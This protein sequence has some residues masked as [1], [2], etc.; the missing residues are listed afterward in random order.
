[1]I[2]PEIP[3]YVFL[4]WLCEIVSI[5]LL[6]KLVPLLHKLATFS[7]WFLFP[8]LIYNSDHIYYVLLF[9][10]LYISIIFTSCEE[11]FKELAQVAHLLSRKKK[12]LW[13]PPK[14]PTFLFY[15]S[16]NAIANLCLIFPFKFT[17]FSTDNRV[18]KWYFATWESWVWFEKKY[19]FSGRPRSILIEYILPTTRF[20]KK[21]ITLPFFK[22]DLS[23]QVLEF[24]NSV[25]YM[26]GIYTSII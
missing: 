12:E 17:F 16:E 23:H 22:S 11:I 20:L 1:M 3:Q 19:R 14:T 2:R 6:H 13:P 25:K 15:L 9:H 10:F 21:K 8:V 24:Q 26:L 18:D 7:H 4:H 5:P